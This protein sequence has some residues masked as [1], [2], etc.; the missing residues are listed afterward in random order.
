[1]PFDIEKKLIMLLNSICVALMQN[2]A[3]LDVFFQPHA[4]NE[5]RK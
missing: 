5:Q 1:M 2:L 4:E 3:L